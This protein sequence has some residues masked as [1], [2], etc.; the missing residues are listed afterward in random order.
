MNSCRAHFDGNKGIQSS[1]GSLEGCQVGIFIGKNSEV[2]W[3][4]AQADT[5][6]NVFLS[7]LKPGVAQGLKNEHKALL[8]WLK[9]TVANVPSGKSSGG[10]RRRSRSPLWGSQIMLAND[11][12]KTKAGRIEYGSRRLTGPKE[13]RR[14]D[15]SI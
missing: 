11:E 9:D 5:C 2:A 15:G 3:L 13:G 4:Y 7:G 12:G 8:F 14:P 6:R 10:Q 1:Y